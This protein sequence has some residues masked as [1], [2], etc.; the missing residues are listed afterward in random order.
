MNKWKNTKRGCI[1]CTL[2][3]ICSAIA[4]GA[5]KDIRFNRDIKPILSENCFT[6]HGPDENKRAAGLRL[7][8]FEGATAIAESGDAAIVPGKPEKSALM[9][10]ILSADPDLRMPPADTGK[11]VS[12]EQ[13]ALLQR[14]I[15]NGAE[16]QGHWAFQRPDRPDIPNVASTNRELQVND[17]ANPI[18]RFVQQKLAEVGLK[19]SP[20]ADRIKL[21]RRVALD[22]TGLPPTPEQVEAYLSDKSPNAYESMVDR[23]LT[24]PAYGERMAI[25]WLDY[26]RY[27]DSNGFQS[28]GSRDIWAWR[29]WVIDAYNSNKPFDQFTIEQLAGDML[30]D[31]TQEQIIAT[32][33]NRNHRLN[34]EGGRIEAE[35]FVETVIDRV[36]TTGLTWMGLTLNCC[37]CH[38]HK[39]DPI[40]QREF[41]QLFAFFNSNDESGVLAPLGKNGENTPPLLTLTTPESEAQIAR[42]HQNLSKAKAM[43]KDAES[44]LPKALEVWE[45]SMADQLNQP[46]IWQ[47]QSPSKVISV[48]GAEFQGLDDGSFL[49]TG[50]N[51]PRDTY[52][53][54]IPLSDALAEGQSLT[55][56]MLEV[57][58]DE[59]LP[60]KSLG[61]GSNGNFVLTDVVAELSAPTLKKPLPLNVSRAAADYEQPSWAA[62]S[63]ITRPVTK[64]S[65]QPAR[66]GWAV[67]GNDPTKRLNR[68]LMFALAQP[69]SVP[70]NATLHIQMRHQSPYADHNVGR[71][72]IFVSQVDPSLLAPTGSNLAPEIRA[73]LATFRSQ[74][75]AQ[76]T[77]ALL[78]FF[79]SSSA[80]P[81]G[82]AEAAVKAAEKQ[83][84]DYRESLPTTMVMKERSQPRDAFV[85]VRGEYDQPAEKVE[86]RLPSFLPPLP[87]G[88][89]ANRLGL[90]R[91]IVSEDNPLT[92]RVWVNREWERFF[93]TGIVKTTENFGSQSEFPSH[94]ELLD[95]LAVEFMQ[96]TMLPAVAGRKAHTWDMKALQK[97]ILMSH[98]YRQS[99]VVSEK[100]I[101]S[102]PENR[103]LSRASRFRLTGELLRD[104][105]LFVSGLLVDRIGGPS[106]RPYMPE[107]VWDE[108]SKYGNLR[109]YKHDTGE[110]LYRRTLYTIWKRTAAPPTMLLFDAPNR[111]VCT[112]KRSRTNTPLQALALLNEVTFVEAARALATR[113]ITEGG[114]SASDRMTYGFRIITG[115]A[116]TSHESSVLLQGLNEDLTRF[117]N[118][119]NAAREVIQQGE[120][121]VPA[122]IPP[123]QLAAWTLTCNILMNLDEFVTRE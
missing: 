119:P 56:F 28:D 82:K 1:L 29:D 89:P 100:Q 41:Y 83:V 37:R 65:P 116:P 17:S 3:M 74:R 34:G 46:D 71:F 122:N 60:N 92:A 55:G 48:G 91:W 90:A 4:S 84:T 102:D 98:T 118:E 33:F 113:I 18:D 8:Q 108:T 14:W 80:S 30:P 52:E 20:E 63:V 86:R 114:D 53:I 70:A 31:A 99:S 76:Q 106:V 96:P 19:H 26:A 23:Y 75:T 77:A 5:E 103:W 69:V 39:Y 43:L 105:A 64:G 35:W 51:P 58:P 36:E 54:D 81:V 11:Q 45:Q 47:L 112:I 67:D 87:E 16:Y 61:R 121:P 24:S 7:D 120:S 110:G 115:R 72:R 40:S 93:G 12:S 79:Q 10:R 107:G 38:D 13:V 95:W 94:P 2:S 42:L 104:Q 21:I 97:L 59:R 62:T 15:Q 50:K 32:G 109:G 68:R 57:I 44:Q 88:E 6:C 123:E 117:S 25:S 111:E 66:K 49:A 101:A 85:L 78:K 27:A 9:Q 73:I 22:L